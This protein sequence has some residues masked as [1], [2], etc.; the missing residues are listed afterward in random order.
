M[1][2]D[3]PSSQDFF[4]SGIE[5]FDFAWDTVAALLTNL[6]QAE[7][8]GID[9]VEVSEEYWA[10]AKRR[11]TTALAMTQQGVEFILKGKIAEISP[12]LLLAEGPSK[13]PSP[14]GDCKPNF[15]EF[16]TVD[17]QDLVRLHD[18]VQGERLSPAFVQQFN[19]LRVKRNTISHSIDKKLQVHTSE[20]IE[21]I[22]SLHKALF[23]EKN[24]AHVRASF[25]K[26][27]PDAK[28]DGGEYS[29]NN[30]CHEL[31]VVVGLLA[32]AAVKE[33]FRID[34]KQRLYVCPACLSD[35]NTDAGFEYKLAV[36]KPKG[37][38]STRVYCPVCD[39]E[40]PV[41]REHCGND[42]CS[43]NV[44]SDDDGTCLTCGR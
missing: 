16:K 13:W 20:V 15:S 31:S 38:K 7:E 24:W 25:L 14:Y 1:I 11:L 28:L 40:Y 35:A 21:A 39:C 3:V 42:E 9:P 17:A 12:Y 41:I 6:A 23:P 18:T 44:L 2:V 30:A 34:K 22:L 19:A 8:W 32:P 33:F 4:D 26:N 37:S 29:T 43:G 27:Y 36:L 5:L 10:A